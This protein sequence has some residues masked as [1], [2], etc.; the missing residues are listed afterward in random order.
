[1]RAKS[2]DLCTL[3]RS[4]YSVC[5]ASPLENAPYFTDIICSALV[6][7]EELDSD[8]DAPLRYASLCSGEEE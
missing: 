2:V 3:E 4:D 7:V 5:T 6:S 8:E 1:M